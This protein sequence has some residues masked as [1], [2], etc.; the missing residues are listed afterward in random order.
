MASHQHGGSTAGATTQ[1]RQ[2][3]G[4]SQ[5]TGS[6]AQVKEATQQA[7]EQFKDSAQSAAETLREHGEGFFAEQKTKAASELSNLSSAIREAADKLRNDQN[8]QTARYAE[9]AADQLDGAARFIGD[10]N[11]G[12]LL[13]EVE[14]AARRRPELFLGGMF[15]IGLGVSRFLKA[16]SQSGATQSSA[17]R[18]RSSG[19]RD[20]RTQGS[21]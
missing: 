16:S 19:T 5:S 14:R 17:A 18:H 20:W 8:S 10:Q 12:S 13:S 1:P 6:L 21:P 2:T 15:L 3:G 4:G 11:V 9:M 7:G